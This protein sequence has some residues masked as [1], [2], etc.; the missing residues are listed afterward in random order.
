MS[1]QTDRVFFDNDP[2]RTP[3]EEPNMQ[4]SAGNT[5]MVG[6]ILVST[7][8]PDTDPG[9]R[10]EKIVMIGLQHEPVAH[11]R[12]IGP[13]YADTEINLNQSSLNISYWIKKEEPTMSTHT[14]AP[15]TTSQILSAAEDCP[16]AERASKRLYPKVFEEDNLRFGSH[17][18]DNVDGKMMA[19]TRDNSTKILLDDGYNWKL[20]PETGPTHAK[21]VPTRK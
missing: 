7:D 12:R 10:C 18:I 5:F 6:D 11:F 3:K 16:D 20:I 1:I 13:R 9:I 14:P 21:V 8:C 4:D 17:Q 15:P 19:W 2:Y